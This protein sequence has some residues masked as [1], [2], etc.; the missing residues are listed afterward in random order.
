MTF[1]VQAGNNYE[2]Q[3]TLKPGSAGTFDYLVRYSTDGGDSW[4]YADLSGP[5]PGGAGAPTAGRP[6]RQRAGRHDGARGPDRP[7]RR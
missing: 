4:T 1:N 3:A 6:H 5:V 2:Y 7:P